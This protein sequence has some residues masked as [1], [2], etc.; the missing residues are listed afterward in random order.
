VLV[1]GAGN[2]WAI[3]HRGPVSAVVG[4]RGVAG[5]GDHAECRRV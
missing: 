2:V 5:I 4:R 3:V 1:P